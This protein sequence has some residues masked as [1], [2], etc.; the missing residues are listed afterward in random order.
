MIA[1]SNVSFRVTSHKTEYSNIKI[2][3]LYIGPL[4]FYIIVFFCYYIQLSAYLTSMARTLMVRLPRLF[5]I[6]SWVLGTNPIVADFAYF[7]WLSFSHWEK[8]YCVNSLE[9]PRSGDSNENTQ[10]TFMLKKIEKI[11]LLCL[12]TWLYNNPQWLEPPLSRT[13]FH[14]PKGVRA[15]EVRLYFGLSMFQ[16]K[17]LKH[18]QAEIHLWV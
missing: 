16:C 11:S 12:L 7:G 13:N 5:R 8:V 9:S 6:H 3:L 14:S 15:I 10:Y 4:W 1:L 17:S 18:W 2:V